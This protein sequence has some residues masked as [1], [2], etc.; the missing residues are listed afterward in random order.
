MLN[1]RIGRTSRG[2]VLSLG[3]AGLAI[4]GPVWCE[5]SPGDAGSLPASANSTKGA[6]MNAVIKGTLTGFMPFTV[7]G[8]AER[9]EPLPADFEDMYLIRIVDPINFVASTVDSIPGMQTSFDSQ[10]F[11]F[12][13]QGRGV[14]ANRDDPM[15]AAGGA[16][17]LANSNDGSG[18]S[19]SQPG[20]YYLAISGQLNDPINEAGMPI[21]DFGDPHEISG[22]DGVMAN[23]RR[24]DS[25][26][27]DGPFGDYFIQLQGVS[28]AENPCPG[29]CDL[30][31]IIDFNDLVCMLFEFGSPNVEGD[32][33]VNG[34]VNFNDLICALFRFGPCD[35][36]VPGGS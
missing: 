21:F 35:A 3:L 32:C 36:M 24:V 16:T 26:V 15:T 34:I 28:F 13:F 31:G 23:Q 14:L 1:R 5:P 6:G 9:G 20:L 25:W 30:N 22:P 7:R 18:A 27:G 17:L 19:V 29:D 2:V 33:D 8:S 12:D 11:L 4:A 10:L